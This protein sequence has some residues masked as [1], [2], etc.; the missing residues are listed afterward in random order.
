[1]TLSNVK[2]RSNK[3]Y[4]KLS[5]KEAEE[6]PRN[7]LYLYLIGPHV[8]RGKGWK[9]NVH[10]KV[11][12]MIDPVTG[13]FEITQYN[14]KRS[15]SISNLVETMWLSRY[16]IPMDITYDQGSEFIGRELRKFLIET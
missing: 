12:T 14:D 3:K 7:N 6:I 8:I 9:E 15:I 13:W 1:M 10:L 4:G 5:A 2:K 16:L 11:I